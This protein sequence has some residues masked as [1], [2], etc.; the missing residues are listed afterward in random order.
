MD[1]LTES[2]NIVK[3]KKRI[4][5]MILAFITL[6][7]GI[8]VVWW[9]FVDDNGAAKLTQQVQVPSSY[10]LSYETYNR[11]NVCIPYDINLCQ[12]SKKAFEN[13]PQ[14]MDK[15]KFQALLSLSPS[16]K[17]ENVNCVDSQFYKGQSCS[18]EVTKGNVKMLVWYDPSGNTPTFRI[19]AGKI[20]N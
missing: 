12:N 15:K 7:A 13:V 17:F 11:G 3:R 8:Y 4:V 2:S 14:T 6:L 16:L 9:A 20:T 18:A 19:S 1:T 10:K 5:S